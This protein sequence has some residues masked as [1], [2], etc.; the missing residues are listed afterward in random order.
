[1][2]VSLRILLAAALLLAVILFRI[3]PEQ[4]IPDP[5]RPALPALSGLLSREDPSLRWFPKK[6]RAARRGVALAVHGLNLKP[7]RMGAVIAV[8]NNAG[9]DV[10][11]VALRGHGDNFT[12]LDN[13]TA[14]A[15]RLEA[16][17]TVTFPLWRGEV[18]RAYEEARRR[19]D[20]RRVPLFFVGYSLGGLLG[21]DLVLSGPDVAVDRMALFAPALSVQVEAHLLKALTPFPGLVIDSLSPRWY[22]ANDGTPMAA[23]KALFEA[24]ARVEGR[25]GPR[26]NVPTLVLVDE[27]DEF[28]SPGRI[29]DLIAA[30]G[31]TRWRVVPVRKDEAV[32]GTASHHLIIDEAAVGKGSWK[33]IEGALVELFPGPGEFMK[34]SQD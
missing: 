13:R 28:I 9:V 1:M 16:F 12:P 27:A 3:G 14:E 17:R 19:A 10:L 26:L 11:N 4:P 7:E 6:R 29:R 25:I 33:A 30:G 31:L 34:R 23:Y 21:C 22:R 5:S 15:A 32:A 20:R 2:R 8:L 18:R 24:V